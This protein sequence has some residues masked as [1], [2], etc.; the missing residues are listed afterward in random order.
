MCAAVSSDLDDEPLPRLPPLQGH[1][2]LTC[3]P[4][5][6]LSATLDLR[7]AAEAEPDRRV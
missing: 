1:L 3:E 2:G 6:A 5:E 4:T 7:L